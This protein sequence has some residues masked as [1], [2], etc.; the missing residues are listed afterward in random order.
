MRKKLSKRERE[1]RQ[2]QAA[3]DRDR[4]L[5]TRQQVADLYGVSVATI[6]RMEADGRL[7]GLKLGPSK[8]HRTLYRAADVERIAVA[9]VE[10]G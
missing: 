3:R 8:N 2:H 1:R 5:Y 9:G 6:I 4:L 10:L 7:L